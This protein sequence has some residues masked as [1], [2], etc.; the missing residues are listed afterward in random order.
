[1]DH[2]DE[3]LRENIR[4]DRSNSRKKRQKKSAV[5]KTLKPPSL[6]FQDQGRGPRQFA[7]RLEHQPVD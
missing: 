6:A 5:R 2:T 1:M 7:K 3:K 4:S